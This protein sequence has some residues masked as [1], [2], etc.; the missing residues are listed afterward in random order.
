MFDSFEDDVKEAAQRVHGLFPAYG[1]RIVISVQGHIRGK[2]RVNVYDSN[3]DWV[4][5]IMMDPEEVGL[6]ASQQ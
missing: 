6:A 4:R 3:G 1:S 2:I 5:T